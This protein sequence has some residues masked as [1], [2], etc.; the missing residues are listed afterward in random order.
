MSAHQIEDSSL[1]GVEEQDGVELF[2]VGMF[3]GDIQGGQF[4]T[5][6]SP[7]TPISAVKSS[8]GLVMVDYWATLLVLQFRFDPQK[9]TCRI[10][11]ATIELIF[12]VSDLD[13]ISPEVEAVSFD[14]S[15]SFLPSKQSETITR[16][17]WEKAVTRETEDATRIIGGKLIVGSM[18]P[19]RKV[20]WAL[21]ENKTLKTGVPA[22]V[23]V[24]SFFGGVPADDPVL[25]EP[26]M[27]PTNKL[28]V[29]NPEELGSVD[30]RK[31][32]D[33]TFTTMIL[34]AQNVITVHGLCDDHNTVWTS[35]KGDQWVGQR[36]FEH[37][38][39]R[40]L[41]YLYPTDE[42]ARVFQ[43]DGI[44][45]EARNLLRLYSEYRRE[46]SDTEVDKPI[47]WVC[48]DI[49]GTIVK[50][51]LIEAAQATLAKDYEDEETWEYMKE[52]H[53]RIATLSTTIIFLSCPHQAGSIDT[54]KDELHNLISLPGPDIKNGVMR[55]IRNLAQQVDKINLQFLDTKLSSRLVSIKVFHLDALKTDESSD[56]QTDGTTDPSSALMELPTAPASPFS[57][58]TVT[59]HHTFSALGV[60]SQE[61][62]SQADLVRGDGDKDED[63]SWVLLL[64]NASIPICT[65]PLKVDPSLIHLQTALLSMAPPTRLP[66]VHM[67]PTVP[68]DRQAPLPR[69]ALK[70]KGIQDF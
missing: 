14:G 41:D 21:L 34:D 57:R 44:K 68:E 17:K 47:I 3:E 49:G 16:A 40:Q 52:A 43:E 12:D 9:R 53:R 61:A 55:K 37:L 2:D 22:S 6:T 45:A 7:R 13:G 36:L 67:D 59:M 38:S 10:S 50:Q 27:K 32:S 70:S 39:V 48:H 42:S 11:E 56:N 69:L 28:I 58:Y 66:K 19:N 35:H 62:I 25:L 64:K 54:L 30:L 31:L 1:E 51:V 33:V 23:R 29:Y 26:D 20:K 5:K 18:P 60:F 63:D 46:L 65:V 8:S 15:Y 4:H 24:A